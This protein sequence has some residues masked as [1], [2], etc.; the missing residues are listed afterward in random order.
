MPCYEYVCAKGHHFDRSLRV[1]DY[2]TP[3]ECFCGAMGR[4][5]ISV[6]RLVMAR[7]EIRYDS[8]VTGKPITSM[9]QRRDDLARHNC[10]EYDPEM[11][12]DAARFRQR[13]DA[14]LDKSVDEH[15]ERAIA[16]MPERKREHLINEV[17]AGATVEVERRSP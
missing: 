1:A 11:K 2:A 16:E 8:P 9:A 7:P 17:A 4:R 5:I 3:Q 13:Q 15:V 10:R 14:A 12:T 6:P